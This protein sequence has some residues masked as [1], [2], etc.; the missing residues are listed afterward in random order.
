MHTLMLAS[1]LRRT[2][3]AGGLVHADRL[4]AWT[5]RDVGRQRRVD[6]RPDARLVT[7]EDDVHVGMRARPVDR[8]AHDLL[9]CVVA[10]HGIDGD[11]RARQVPSRRRVRVSRSMPQRVDLPKA[12]GGQRPG[13]L[14]GDFLAL[15]AHRLAAA[16]PAAVGARVVRPLGLV[17]V[18][19]L[20]QLRRR[21]RVVRAAIAL[22]GVE[23]RR[24]GTPIRL[25]S[26]S[27]R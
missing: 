26:P 14:L 15:D 18:R 24:L 11:A 9:G 6:E 23:T 7:D 21:Q 19:A 17:A 4:A 5:M 3:V 10:A 1:R 16:V 25:R 22:P 8:A 20:L 2:A 13:A 27:C 12:P